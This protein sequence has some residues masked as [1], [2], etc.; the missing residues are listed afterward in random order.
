METIDM[1]FDRRDR[2]YDAPTDTKGSM[3]G[4]PW[5]LYA[6]KSGKDFMRF[7]LRGERGV[8]PFLKRV[9]AGAQDGGMPQ[10]IP[11]GEAYREVRKWYKDLTWREVQALGSKGISKK[12]L[13][14]LVA[15]GGPGL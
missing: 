11:Q 2:L 8:V 14:S 9:F 12:T 3:S 1:M 10:G 7:K 5:F 4:I 6:G 15:G 13:A